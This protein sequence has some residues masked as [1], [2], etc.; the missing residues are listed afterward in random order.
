MKVIISQLLFLGLEFSTK[1]R[2]VEWVYLELSVNPFLI[3][4]RLPVC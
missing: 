3:K 4:L 1:V 2:K